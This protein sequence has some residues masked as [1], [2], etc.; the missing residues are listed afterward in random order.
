MDAFVPVEREDDLAV[1][2]RLEVVSSGILFTD[3]AVVV[4]FPLTASI[5]LRSGE[6]E[7]AR[8][9]ADRRWKGV[10]DTRWLSCHNK[11][12]SSPARGGGF[13]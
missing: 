1:A 6:K 11:Y 10:R 9:F 2:A 13:S 8:R 3:L 5:C 4:D 7:A 12:R